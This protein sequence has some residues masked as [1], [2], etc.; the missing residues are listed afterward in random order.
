MSK[1]PAAGKS[2]PQDPMK[3][4]L[5]AVRA[6]IATADQIRQLLTECVSKST[7]L[8]EEQKLIQDQL[9]AES[10]AR[11]IPAADPVSE[12]VDYISGKIKGQDAWIEFLRAQATIFRLE[13][14]GGLPP[15]SIPKTSSTEGSTVLNLADSDDEFDPDST[16]EPESTKAKIEPPTANVITIDAEGVAA[17]RHFPNLDGGFRLKYIEVRD[18]KPWDR[19]IASFQSFFPGVNTA[20][21]EWNQSLRQWWIDH[22]REIWERFFWLGT[23]AYSSASGSIDK[24]ANACKSRLEGAKRVF[25]RLVNALHDIEGDTIFYFLLHNVHPF[26]PSEVG[27]HSMKIT[28]LIVQVNSAEAIRYLESEGQ[29]RWPDFSQFGQIVSADTLAQ[30]TM[31]TPAGR[32]QGQFW[33]WISAMWLNDVRKAKCP[34]VVPLV[35]GVVTR[36]AED[37]VEPFPYVNYPEGI[38]PMPDFLQ[39]QQTQDPNYVGRWIGSPNRLQVLDRETMLSWR[40]PIRL[41]FVRVK[42]RK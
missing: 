27:L 41:G 22:G 12:F 42:V 11:A 13:K 40:G 34:W 28:D 36:Q 3:E 7:D 6:S 35:A 32:R 37:R 31:T 9:K 4:T 18:A 20:Q 19:W 21:R 15:P 24:S 39:R 26:W 25:V 8:A 2:V 5:K 17:L 29:K 1:K 23:G 14:G 33:S 16:G 10:A 30:L 38:H